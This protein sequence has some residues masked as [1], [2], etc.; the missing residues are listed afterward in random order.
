MT[1]IPKIAQLR[2]HLSISETVTGLILSG[3][4]TVTGFNSE[5][6]SGDYAKMIQDIKL[7][8]PESELVIKYGNTI[9][10][11]ARHAAPIVT[12][13]QIGRAHV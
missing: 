3:K 5:Y 13:K 2:D 9:I 12:G 4:Q 7:G 8:V 11:T 10:Q 1:D 6:F